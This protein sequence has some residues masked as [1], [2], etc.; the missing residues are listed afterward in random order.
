MWMKPFEKDS[1]LC[2]VCVS[3]STVIMQIKCLVLHVT[4][5]LL[6]KP[7]LNKK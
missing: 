7:S 5:Y 2:V 1:S 6:V 4:V 3:E